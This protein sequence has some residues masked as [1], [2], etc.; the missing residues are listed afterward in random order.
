[1]STSLLCLALLLLRQ[2]T[3]DPETFRPI[4]PVVVLQGYHRLEK[5]SFFVINSQ[6]QAK[7]I[8]AQALSTDDYLRA[9]QVD[10]SRFTTLFICHPRTRFL[11]SLDFK[12][13]E[14]SAKAINIGYS[15][16]SLDQ[17]FYG[18]NDKVA[19]AP[20]LFVVV[21]KWEG[22]TYFYQQKDT[23]AQKDSRILQSKVSSKE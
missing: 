10:Y 21:P 11:L 4:R 6:E 14:E 1:M 2:Q 15:E 22:T 12:W 18:Y 13:V 7:S 23:P 20:Y 3:E 16:S 8:F 5:A 9:P 19:E 17:I